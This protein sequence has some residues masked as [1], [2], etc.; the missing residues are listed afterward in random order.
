MYTKETYRQKLEAKLEKA[1]LELIEL[2][3][4]ARSAEGNR[5][6]NSPAPIKYRIMRQPAPVAAE[7]A[8]APL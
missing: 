2:N 4:R 1:Q 8:N 5:S 6:R 3:A 7:W